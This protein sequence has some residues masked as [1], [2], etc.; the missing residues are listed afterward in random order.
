MNLYMYYLFCTFLLVSHVSSK[1]EYKP[2]SIFM[3]DGKT[4]VDGQFEAI[5]H[6]G[7]FLRY[8]YN[9]LLGAEDFR[10][11]TQQERIELKKKE[12]EFELQE[13]SDLMEL[14]KSLKR[15]KDEFIA[16]LNKKLD[17]FYSKIQPEDDQVRLQDEQ[18]SESRLNT[19]FLSGD[20]IKEMV[21]QKK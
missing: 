10:T 6:E 8:V 7:Q 12:L 15:E 17:V 18:Q 2:P 11:L 5:L 16:N 9:Q 20:S 4:Y 19:E 14:Q 21:I 3:V 13:Q 1:Y